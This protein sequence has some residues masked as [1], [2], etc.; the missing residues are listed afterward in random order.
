M[1]E[2]DVQASMQKTHVHAHTQLCLQHNRSVAVVKY[3]MARNLVDKN[4]VNCSKS[5]L[6]IK[7]LANEC[8][9]VNAHV[10]SLTVRACNTSLTG[11]MASFCVEAMVRGH[12]EYQNIWTAISGERLK[13]ARKIG[14]RSDLFAVA[15]HFGLR[16]LVH[17]TPIDSSRSVWIR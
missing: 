2:I 7:T 16:S 6:V 8:Q 4:L 9:E 1:R 17:C 5:I 10:H 11:E 14:N 3:R 15:V 12:H 13:C